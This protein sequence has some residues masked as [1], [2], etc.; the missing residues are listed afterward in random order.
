M[1][2]EGARGLKV[3]MGSEGGREETDQPIR[4][5]W[6]CIVRHSIRPSLGVG[7]LRPG[8]HMRPVKLLNLACGT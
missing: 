3:I 2:Y 1:D 8:G 7:K 5:D 6:F 4:V